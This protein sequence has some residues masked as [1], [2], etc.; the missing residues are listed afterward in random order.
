MSNK[1]PRSLGF[2]GGIR[3]GGSR[4]RPIRHG[5]HHRGGRRH[6]RGGRADDYRCGDGD[7]Y[8]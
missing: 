8:R 3:P 1:E 5:G 2:P 7:D 6:H 4:L